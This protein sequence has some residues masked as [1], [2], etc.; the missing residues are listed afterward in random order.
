MGGI[1]RHLSFANVMAAIAV[2]VALGGG[3]IAATQSKSGGKTKP[4][5][6]VVKANGDL[7]RGRGAVSAKQLF[8]PDFDGAY[9]V[10][11]NRRV[12]NCAL[13]A[14]IGRVNSAP[15][16]PDPGEI[17]VAYRDGRADSVFVKTRDSGGV[18]EDQSFHLA[19]L[20]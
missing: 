4:R 8:T 2:F 10:T 14:T 18:A 3:A 12:T 9:Q 1:R 11:F 5:W 13:I 17:G 16:N 15:K 19:V 20:C 6:A 7:V